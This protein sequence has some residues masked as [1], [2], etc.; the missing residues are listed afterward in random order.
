MRIYSQGVNQTKIKIMKIV[1]N[2]DIGVRGK[3]YPHFFTSN[4]KLALKMR[5]C[6]QS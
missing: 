1:I 6:D 3:G 2:K 4:F 5:G